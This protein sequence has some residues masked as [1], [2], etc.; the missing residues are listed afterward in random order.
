MTFLE[1]S[2]K[3]YDFYFKE[4]RKDSEVILYI[5]DQILIELF[6]DNG[7][8]LFLSLFTSIEKQ[9]SYESRNPISNVKGIEKLSDA[10]L[11]RSPLYI[12]GVIKGKTG[13][14]LRGSDDL[15]YNKSILSL[16]LLLIYAQNTEK[17]IFL[18]DAEK[19]SVGDEQKVRK[20][21][22]ELLNRF[23][24]KTINN[25]EKGFVNFLNLYNKIAGESY[26][27]VGYFK[28]HTPLTRVLFKTVLNIKNKNGFHYEIKDTNLIENLFKEVLDDNRFKKNR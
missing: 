26:Q 5:D 3:L 1:A 25:S 20:N 6:G 13:K 10:F 7:V 8:E 19:K 23:S 9:F 28:Y 12:L 27:F 22:V 17:G 4:S 21:V 24:K 14:V 18:S 16:I 2:D 15:D 11:N